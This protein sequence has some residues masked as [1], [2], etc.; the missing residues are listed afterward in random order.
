VIFLGSQPTTV[1]ERLQAAIEERLQ[2]AKME[3]EAD[4]VQERTDEE[5]DK[6][7]TEL[8]RLKRRYKKK[9][10]KVKAHP[11]VSDEE[12]DRQDKLRSDN[13]E[14]QTKMMAACEDKGTEEANQEASKLTEVNSQLKKT[15]N[16]RESQILKLEK[17]WLQRKAGWKRRADN[18]ASQDTMRIAQLQAL[19]AHLQ[20]SLTGL[21]KNGAQDSTV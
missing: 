17:R 14:L 5:I 8:R 3:A 9:L 21:Q 13:S 15:L 2:K 10:A 6:E 1:G 12:K 11:I 20:Q 4:K 7:R 16:K 18:E 19:V